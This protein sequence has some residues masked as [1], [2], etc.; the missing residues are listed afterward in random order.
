MAFKILTHSH[1]VSTNNHSNSSTPI[2]TMCLCKLHVYYLLKL[3]MC[4]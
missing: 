1:T 2:S 3:K 4:W